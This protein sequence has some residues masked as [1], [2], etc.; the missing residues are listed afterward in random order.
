M[1]GYNTLERGVLVDLMVVSIQSRDNYE[2]KT[3]ERPFWL[4]Y[5]RSRSYALVGATSIKVNIVRRPADA[6]A[7]FGQGLG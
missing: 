5:I 4:Q 2:E 3:S 7:A 1:N 6:S